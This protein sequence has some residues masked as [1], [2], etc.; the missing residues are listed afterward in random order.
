M[1][2]FAQDIENAAYQ[3]LVQ[4]GTPFWDE[5]VIPNTTRFYD[6]DTFDLCI[7]DDFLKISE[8]GYVELRGR[9]NIKQYLP[10]IKG[11]DSVNRIA[12]TGINHVFDT[13]PDQFTLRSESQIAISRVDCIK[14]LIIQAKNVQLS[15]VNSIFDSDL[16]GINV[17][18]SDTF[19]DFRNC[20]FGESN[21]IYFTNIHF[22]NSDDSRLSLRTFIDFLYES[23]CKI[24]SS[25][26]DV[27]TKPQTLGGIE[28]FSIYEVLKIP[29]TVKFIELYLPIQNI[30][31][32]KIIVNCHRAEPGD[33]QTLD[34]FKIEF[35]YV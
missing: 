12:C 31:S 1:S 9:I 29:N 22:N 33:E 25:H 20:Q 2:I 18:V 24:I 35:R 30:Y 15:Y 23:I 8:N 19:T 34:G 28:Y 13:Y 17:L 10:H 14:N 6:T 5:W 21:Q 4:P 26:F 11:I 27:G 3:G 32:H 7:Q 16:S